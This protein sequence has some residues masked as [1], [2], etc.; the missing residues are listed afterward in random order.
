MYSDGFSELTDKV[1]DFLTEHGIEAQGKFSCPH[2]EHDDS[3]PSAHVYKDKFVKCFGCGRTMTIFD[4]AHYFEALPDKGT[5]EFFKGNVSVL[6]KRYGIALPAWSESPILD[7]HSRFIEYVKHEY[8]P[9]RAKEEGKSLST[10]YH[11]LVPHPDILELHKT[12]PIALLGPPLGEVVDFLVGEGFSALQIRCAGFIGSSYPTEECVLYPLWLSHAVCIGFS[13][14]NPGG[15][16]KYLNSP[17]NDCFTKG[18]Y[19]YGLFL[20]ADISK[21]LYVVEGQKDCLAL[22]AR[23]FQAVAPLG[24]H[25]TKDQI[26]IIVSRGFRHVVMCSDGDDA[27]RRGALGSI[28][29]FLHQGVM[30]KISEM[31]EGL[32]P[33][34]YLMRDGN[35]EPPDSKDGLEVYVDSLASRGDLHTATAKV[36]D[37]ISNV[38]HRIQRELMSA[39]IAAYLQVS[40]DALAEDVESLVSKKKEL[41][42]NSILS[43]LESGML[44]AK[45]DPEH[46]MNLMKQAYD[47][48][49]EI[50]KTKE[51]H[52][53]DFLLELVKNIESGK[54]SSKHLDIHFRKEGLGVLS[55]IL[56]T[57]GIGWTRGVL[58]AVGGDPHCGK[59]AI[60][61]QILV[62]SLI[63]HVDVMCIHFSTDD[64]SEV[65]LPRIVSALVFNPDFYINHSIDPKLEGARAIMRTAALKKIQEW[66]STDR[67]IMKDQHFSRKF[68][69]LASLVHYYRDKYPNRRIIVFN[70]NFHKNADYSEKDTL[71]KQSMLANDAKDLAVSNDLSVWCTV[72]YRKN[73]ENN[74]NRRSVGPVSA[75]IKGDGS[76]SYNASLILNLHND[77][78]DQNGDIESSVQVHEHRGELFPRVDVHV[79]KNKISGKLG[80]L[81]MNLFPNCSF[82]TPIDPEVAAQEAAARLESLGGNQHDR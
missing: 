70:D 69:Q 46:A 16:P 27:G 78:I 81:P 31:P 50:A 18:Q 74:S 11:E 4:I 55:D 64:A 25:L 48:A 75:D 43:I 47:Y 80:P 54:T 15:N 33:F 41:K 58:A 40:E 82:F 8:L 24:S 22:W 56:H 57:N 1:S 61:L 9:R 66:A 68:S 42:T 37:I 79:S 39:D 2:P 53:N 3:S 76:L 62:E 65:L 63:Y 34:D 14:K 60:L 7:I 20:G 49:G 73:K 72:E 38:P 36:V 67:L 21:P 17:N 13:L 51:N 5:P 52:N 19:L 45:H 77:F 10:F 29:K 6:A 44:K 28:E 12:Q 71:T 32:D 26:D 30:C 23:G 35:L 59:T